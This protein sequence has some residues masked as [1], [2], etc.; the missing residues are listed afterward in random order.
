MQEQVW[1]CS[2]H[3]SGEFFIF[4]RSGGFENYLIWWNVI[5]VQIC[6]NRAK[7]ILLF[8][9]IS[10]ILTTLI[11]QIGWQLTFVRIGRTGYCNRVTSYLCQKRAEKKLS[12]FIHSQIPPRPVFTIRVVLITK[13]IKY[14]KLS[15]S[16]VFSKSFWQN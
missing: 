10:Q 1:Y 2:R 5:L 12:F 11:I 8:S 9:I 6:Q 16:S 4:E 3:H 13:S 15:T 14:N 7:N